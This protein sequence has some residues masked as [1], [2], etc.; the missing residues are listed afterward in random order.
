MNDE[1]MML[2]TGVDFQG[3]FIT[4]YIDVIFDEMIVG[5]GLLR[6]IASKFDN[7]I[8]TY[9]GTEATVVTKKLNSVKETLRNRVINKA[10]EIGANGLIGIDF[11]SSRVGDL[12]MVS[13][14]ATAVKVERI[15]EGLPKTDQMMNI[16]EA[17]KR[18]KELK[19]E[20]LARIQELKDNVR[21]GDDAANAIVR[22]VEEIDDPSEI[23]KY[24]QEQ[25]LIYPEL[26]PEELLKE[27]SE[28][29]QIS[30]VYGKKA[31]RLKE[32]IKEWYE[33]L[34]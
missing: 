26:I 13:M 14:T 4:E 25:S 9:T 28:R 22:V 20:R 3:Y 24:M 27:I 15:I 5:I 11:E 19:E 1:K 17:A 6:G 18:E 10:R 2:T 7:D 12:L 21:A 32:S 29:V 16:E 8:S 33:N 30:R 23:Q 34:K 31:A